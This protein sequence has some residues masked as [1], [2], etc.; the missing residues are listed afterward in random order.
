MNSTRACLLELIEEGAI[1][2]G[3]LERAVEVSGLQPG[4]RAWSSFLDQILLWFGA[5][6]LA[7]SVLF[8]IAYNWAELGRFARFGLV[9]LALLGAMA[10]YWK[11]DG[12]GLTSQAALMAATLLLGVLLALYGQVYQT[13][14]D[15][16]QLFFTWALLMLPWALIGR[17]AA[18]WLVW[19]GLLNLS[20][21]LYH[22]ALSLLG[23]LFGSSI[24]SMLWS[25]VLINTAALVA[26]QI[27]SHRWPWLERDW[28]RRLVAVASGASITALLLYAIFSSEAP[29]APW[30]LYPVWLAGFYWFYRR[31]QPDLFMLA[32]ACLSGILVVVMLVAEKMIWLKTADAGNF[33]VLTI[34]TLGLSAAAAAWLKRVQRE[35]RL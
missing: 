31:V 8:F 3:D 16:W 13:G 12:R 30:L 5:L 2:P 15:P 26:G 11:Q 19:L 21:V 29:V 33:L 24:L 14:A 9:E 6:A 17:F 28:A 23:F 4:G 7:F 35:I 34:L 22:E 18:L 1:H 27:A 10:V 25:L 32:G 20:V